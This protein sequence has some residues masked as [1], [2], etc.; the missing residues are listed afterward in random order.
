M[1]LTLKETSQK[2][3][4]IKKRGYVKSLRRGP[5]GIG[6]TLETLLGIDENN[7]S[8]PDLGDIE[9]KA[10]RSRHSGMTTLFSFNRNVWK[11]PP[12]E[13]IQKYGSE[14]TNGRLGLYYSM[15]M[16][17][18]SA[19]LFLS[20]TSDSV[21][22][23]SID[24]KIVAQWELQEIEKRFN[25]KVK[26]LLLVKADVDF[27]DGEEYFYFNRARL[28]TGGATQSILKNQFENE[29][30]ILDLR[31]HDQGTS[32]RNHGTAFRMNENGLENF[33]Q[34]VEEVEI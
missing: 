26:N 31:L 8:T 21:L 24:G 34:K 2:L 13:A 19:G 1:A 14:D 16:R 23:R 22:V 9:L 30:L 18:N 10:Q 5:T 3:S 33:Y 7:V 12:L 27:R 20:V 6:Y 11:M 4:E 17:P 29:Q 25:E 15:G 32:A 28:L